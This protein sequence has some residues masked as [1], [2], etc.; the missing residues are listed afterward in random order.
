MKE[1][2]NAKE[3]NRLW[4]IAEEDLY[5]IQLLLGLSFYLVCAV[6]FFVV[7]IGE[8]RASCEKANLLVVLDRSGSMRKGDKWK[9]AT[10]SLLTVN[11]RFQ[12]RVRFGLVSFSRD[13]RVN[14]TLGSKQTEFAM[15]L[16]KIIPSGE[17]Y[18]VKAFSVAKKHLIDSLQKDKTFKRPTSIL[19]LTDGA[20]SDRCPSKEVKELRRLQV[21]KHKHEIKTF[22]VGFGS[23]VN[24]SCLNTLAMHGGT[25]L[26]GSVHYHVVSSETELEPVLDKISRQSFSLETCNGLDD[27][28][29]GKIDNVSGKNVSITRTCYEGKCPGVQVCQSGQ[30]QACRLKKPKS[31]EICNGKDDDCDGFVDN[32]PS[33]KKANSLKKPCNGSCGKGFQTCFHGK[34]GNCSGNGLREKCNGKDDD[35]DGYIDEDVKASCGNCRLRKCTA[36]K[37]GKCEGHEKSK[38]ICNGVD[39][40]CDGFI[41]NH[42]GSPNERLYE[43]CKHKCKKGKRQ[44]WGGVWGA[45][46][47]PLPTAEQCNGKDDDCDG[48]VDEL[49]TDK[50]GKDCNTKCIVGKYLCLPNGWGVYCAGVKEGKELCDGKD[51]DCN[52]FIDEPWPFKGKPC[53]KSRGACQTFGRYVCSKD[54]KELLCTAPPEKP[55]SE[56]V[57]DGI[58]ND[59]DGKTDEG[60]TRPCGSS[61]EDGV[62]L[63]LEGKWSECNKS[64][65]V[66]AKC[67]P[68]QKQ[69]VKESKKELSSTQFSI[70]MSNCGCSTNASQRG[71]ELLWMWGLLLL[72]FFFRIWIRKR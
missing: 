55:K 58:D 4:D 21:G 46:G 72:P 50:L 24:P 34:W 35:C 57:C 62:Q 17:T 12:N 11:Q 16:G 66:V 10:T 67:A 23:H 13:A 40:D 15:N 27:D 48:L 49:W 52:G 28:C 71:S 41:D 18:M 30:W 8:A 54:R 3:S 60:L 31:A 38:E 36:G 53:Q 32:P 19:F 70:R 5:F 63:C 2:Q 9:H 7:M 25:Y 26:S 45:C 22:V 14:V 29:D 69:P 43:P 6:V 47:A 20:P 56:E 64:E 39:D 42:P 59:C 1:Y 65:L 33:T 68:K 44:C 51:N 61:C 37:W